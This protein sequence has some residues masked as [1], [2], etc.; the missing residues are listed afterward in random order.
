MN[1]TVYLEETQYIDSKK[2]VGISG[3]FAGASIELNPG[4]KI[5]VGRDPSKCQLVLNDS[6]VSRVHCCI[7]YDVSSMCTEII[8][9]SPNGIK[10]EDGRTLQKDMK[11]EIT[12]PERLI[13]ANGD[14]VLEIY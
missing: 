10:F 5:M 14:E 8:C 11:M 6:K 3:T 7:S 2:I 1:P 13:L 4:E 12:K 9:Y